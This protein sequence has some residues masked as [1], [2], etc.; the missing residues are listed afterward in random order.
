MSPP[1]A[2]PG[3]ARCASGTRTAWTRACAT[4]C[5][6][7]PPQ[8]F[9]KRENQRLLTAPG[10]KALIFFARDRCPDGPIPTCA[11]SSWLRCGPEST[12][13][14]L[15]KP[16]KGGPACDTLD[17]KKSSFPNTLGAPLGA[18]RG[19]HASASRGMSTTTLSAAAADV[20]A[21]KNPAQPGRPAPEIRAAHKVFDRLEV[22]RDICFDAG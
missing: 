13:N 18:G 10:E 2:L 3:P 20:A 8:A 7:T 11:F 15:A 17:G 1:A 6:R 14:R 9:L 5:P 19:Q 22:I 16:P 4:G 21:R 12:R